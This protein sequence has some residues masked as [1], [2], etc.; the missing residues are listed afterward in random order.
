MS[1]LH[2][3]LLYLV[4]IS[5]ICKARGCYSPWKAYGQSKLATLI[6]ALQLPQRS[7]AA[8]CKLIN[9]AAHP[10]FARTDLFTSGPAGPLSLATDFAAPF[11]GHSAADGARPIVFAATDPEARPGAQYGPKELASREGRRRPR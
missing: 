1:E 9:N 4:S 11:L 6:F 3:S 10:G 5:M 7:D 2:H 8:G